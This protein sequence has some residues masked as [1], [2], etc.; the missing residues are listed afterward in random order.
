M[1]EISK[2]SDITYQDVAEYL[3]L[4]KIAQ[5]KLR[6]RGSSDKIIVFLFGTQEILNAGWS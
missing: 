1:N 4:S 6:G 3:R 5:R 2:V